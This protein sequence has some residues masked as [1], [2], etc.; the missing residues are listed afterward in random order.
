M[1]FFFPE[2][3][4]Y[5]LKPFVGSILPYR[6]FAGKL[7]PPRNDVQIVDDAADGDRG[8]QDASSSTAVGVQPGGRRS[9]IR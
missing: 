5:D 7:S 6:R 9:P 2:A 3:A 1:C 4:G 8:F